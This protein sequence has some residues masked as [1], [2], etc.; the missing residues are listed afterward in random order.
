[1]KEIIENISVWVTDGVTNIW[2]K[3]DTDNRGIFSGVDKYVDVILERSENQVK[4]TGTKILQEGGYTR[5]KILVKN[6]PERPEEEW[7]S[8]D[9]FGREYVKYVFKFHPRLDNKRT[10]IITNNFVICQTF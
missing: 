7:I 10:T 5:H 6:L 4:I 9:F 2:L 8:K 3:A 1:M